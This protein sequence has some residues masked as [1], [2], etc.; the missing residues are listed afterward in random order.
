[1]TATDQTVHDQPPATPGRTEAETRRLVDEAAARRRAAQQMARARARLWAAVAKEEWVSA[2]RSLISL[3]DSPTKRG[4]TVNILSEAAKWLRLLTAVG[5]VRLSLWSIGELAADGGPFSVYAQA[6]LIPST[7]SCEA[8]EVTMPVPPAGRDLALVE[9]PALLEVDEHGQGFGQVDLSHD[10][11]AWLAA[12][13][14]A[15]RP[16]ASS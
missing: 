5:E 15:A 14:A 4:W 3:I 12:A 16:A 1:M 9:H 11:E 6:T 8:V 2:D 13:G 10:H 7:A